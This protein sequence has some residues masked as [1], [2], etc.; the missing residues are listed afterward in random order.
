DQLTNQV[1]ELTSEV[2]ALKGD[3]AA[4]EMKAQEA[5][6]AAMAAKEEADRANDRIDNIAESYTK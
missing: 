1:A 6:A 2:E 3:K 5:A 4:A